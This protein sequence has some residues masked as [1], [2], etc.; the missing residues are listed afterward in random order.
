MNTR[1]IALV[2]ESWERVETAGRLASDLLYERLFEL[3]PGL[4][5]LFARTHMDDQGDRLLMMV[6][7]GVRMLDRFERLQP[8]LR[9]LGERHAR[10]G[11]R[12]D[13]FATFGEALLQGLAQLLGPA[14]TPDLKAA[15][16]EVYTTV[17]T[18]M[19]D[20]AD[21][22]ELKPQMLAVRAG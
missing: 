18:A 16:I 3:D 20:E 21:A 6:G 10:Y 13:H 17:V 15:W 14:F 19:H 9:E 8:A 22:P 7:I 12:W 4:Q 1:D 2:Q 5:A 11:V